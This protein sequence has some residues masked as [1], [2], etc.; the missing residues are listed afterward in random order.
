MRGTICH[1]DGLFFTFSNVSDMVSSPVLPRAEFEAYYLYQAR[2]EAEGELAPRIERAIAQG[3]SSRDGETAYDVVRGNA[4]R[5]SLKKILERAD[6]LGGMDFA[7]ALG[8]L[9][10][11]VRV[12][13]LG[14]ERHVVSEDRGNG[15]PVLS[16]K[17]SI[18]DGIDPYHPC[19]DDVLATDW[20]VVQ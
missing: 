16:L 3:S 19:S 14:W 18:W 12:R 13:R 5:V 6:H 17:P 20:E 1:K 7:T 10:A 15:V 4:E 11:A 9:K 8:L 2:L